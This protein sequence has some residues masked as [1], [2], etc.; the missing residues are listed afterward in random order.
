ME[1]WERSGIGISLVL[2][3][4]LGCDTGDNSM[5]ADGTEP[6]ETR[7]SK[8]RE[9]TEIDEDSKNGIDSENTDSDTDDSLIDV[10]KYRDSETYD[11][12]RSTDE[13][14]CLFK[15]GFDID[16]PDA[17]AFIGFDAI[18]DGDRFYY[19]T[20]EEMAIIDIGA[21]NPKIVHGIRDE[22]SHAFAFDVDNDFIYVLTEAGLWENVELWI[23]SYPNRA[24]D[25]T[26]VSSMWIPD[27]FGINIV[28]DYAI[29]RTLD[30]DAT[31]RM[32]VYVCPLSILH[33]AEPELESC[34]NVDIGDG[35]LVN[36]YIKDDLMFGEFVD[37][38]YVQSGS[39]A[40][41]DI[42]AL[43]EISLLEEY[44]IE[45]YVS[46]I[47]VDDEYVYVSLN[48]TASAGDALILSYDGEGHMAF[49]SKF[50]VTDYDFYS[51]AA[52][53]DFLYVSTGVIGGDLS[54]WDISDPAVPAI[55][56]PSVEVED[57]YV[58]CDHINFNRTKNDGTL[59]LSTSLHASGLL[60]CNADT[61][62]TGNEDNSDTEADTEDD[63][64]TDEREDTDSETDSQNDTEM[65]S[66]ADDSDTASIPETCDISLI[67]SF[68][69]SF[70][71]KIIR[72]DDYI[73]TFAGSEFAIYDITDSTTPTLVGGVRQSFVASDMVVY[74]NYVIFITQSPIYL[75]SSLLIYDTGS[76]TGDPVSIGEVFNDELLHQMAVSNGYL[77]LA[78]ANDSVLLHSPIIYYS[79]DELVS[80]PNNAVRHVF[81]PGEIHFST[82]YANGNHLYS[83][84]PVNDYAETIML[85]VLD[86][87]EP[88]APV[89]VT[90]M[91]ITG[92]ISS[93]H[94]VEDTMYAAQYVKYHA[95]GADDVVV[96]T[97]DP[98]T[99]PVVVGGYSDD[100]DFTNGKTITAAL[101]KV[102]L[103]SSDSLSFPEHSDVG[104]L[105]PGSGQLE[106]FTLDGRRLN[107]DHDP[108]PI[109]YD[110][111]TIVA[112]PE[113][114]NLYIGG[115]ENLY[116]TTLCE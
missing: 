37:N 95:E 14:A 110:F 68:P 64:D 105:F 112:D 17:D 41:Y 39:V 27:A 86:I 11:D 4:C 12:E 8:V 87:Q 13:S 102:Y 111:N 82:V 52:R 9:D 116:I 49:V 100:S 80:D 96:L 5:S 84:S 83:H 104:S 59:Y 74:D 15:K 81:Q 76:K 48:S 107:E 10:I 46:D 73:Y 47:F 24:Q 71:E 6:N 97:V 88:T 51:L 109:E 44:P 7:D 91:T 25:P 79:L 65:E 98:P 36:L 32:P 113:R 94:F 23:Y 45:E 70:P 29:I 103:L 92:G 40:M 20:E 42:S 90:D 108:F 28:G 99:D 89:V 63:G 54:V 18:A 85:K 114:E 2:V 34:R 72:V 101:D 60:I 78:A 53:D 50:D 16:T 61:T 22:F 26:L 62:E 66:D 77:Y 75:Y 93:V 19:L 3:M 58:R 55:I 115:V 30:F 38:N 56:D 35:Q 57:T 67:S 43:P 21:K 31:S 106:I 1:L 69:M 33:Q